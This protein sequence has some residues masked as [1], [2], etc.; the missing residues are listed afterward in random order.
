M[1][2]ISLADIEVSEALGREIERQPHL[3]VK[4]EPAAMQFDADEPTDYA[5]ID[6][7]RIVRFKLVDG[8]LRPKDAEWLDGHTPP[9]DADTKSVNVRGAGAAAPPKSAVERD[10]EAEKGRK[11]AA[12]GTK[13]TNESAEKSAQ[14]EQRCAAA[15]NNYQIFIPEMRGR[16][17]PRD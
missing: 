14:N 15:R 6:A 2:A 16:V 3:A 11:A 12:E 1:S 13:K 10:K 9:P 4:S 5:L 8:A 7:T 17:V